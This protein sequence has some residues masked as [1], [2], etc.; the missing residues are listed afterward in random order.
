MKAID[1][2]KFKEVLDQ[3]GIELF[4]YC[5]ARRKLFCRRRFTNSKGRKKIN[6]NLLRH[7]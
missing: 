3:S 4:S 5:R 1:L 7:N 2:K 6:Y